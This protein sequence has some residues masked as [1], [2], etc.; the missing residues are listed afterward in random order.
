MDKNTKNVSFMSSL[1]L[2]REEIA[3]SEEECM[4]KDFG[5]KSIA[6]EKG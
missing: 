5:P 3:L 4:A 2:P 6:P 1:A